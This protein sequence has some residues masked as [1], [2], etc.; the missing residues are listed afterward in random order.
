MFDH[1]RT[2]FGRILNSFRPRP[3]AEFGQWDL[4]P[5][6]FRIDWLS[7]S[8]QSSSLPREARWAPPVPTRLRNVWAQSQIASRE[9][10]VMLRHENRREQ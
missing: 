8:S 9:A 10:T 4:V 5:Y 6:D 1:I 7:A 2:A 3:V